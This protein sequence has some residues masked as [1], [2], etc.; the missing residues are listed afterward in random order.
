MT[1]PSGSITILQS[2]MMDCTDEYMVLA[3]FREKGLPL[4]GVVSLTPHPDYEYTECTDYAR[5]SITI[6]WTYKGD[7]SDLGELEL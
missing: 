3:I 1:E 5:H 7:A 6:T 4:A 2:E